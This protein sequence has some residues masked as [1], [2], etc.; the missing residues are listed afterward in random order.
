M[1]KYGKFSIHANFYAKK[2][3]K[4]YLFLFF[5]DIGQLQ[6]AKKRGKDVSSL[7]KDAPRRSMRVS[8]GACE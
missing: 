2:I 3:E 5:I 7:P 6:R 4:N 8:R 1:Q